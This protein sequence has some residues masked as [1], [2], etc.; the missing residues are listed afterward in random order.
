MRIKKSRQAIAGL[1]AA[2]TLIL[3]GLFVLTPVHAA[4]RLPPLT[5][6]PTGEWTPGKFVWFEL[7]TRALEPQQQFYASVFGWRFTTIDEG[8]NH[9]SLIRND[10]QPVA[11]MFE[12]KQQEGKLGAL[13]IAFMSSKD[14]ELVMAAV[15]RSGGSVHTAPVNL[16]DRGVHALFRDPQ[17]ALFGVL[18][19]TRGDPLD[20]QAAIGSIIWLDLFAR[21]V[22]AAADFYQKV[23]PYQ[24]ETSPTESGEPENNGDKQIP[25]TFLMSANKHRAGIVSLPEEANRA[26]WLPYVRVSDV[27]TTLEKVV[28]SGGHVMV[29]PDTEL[30]NGN[31]AIFADPQG[32]I[33]GI[34][35]WDETETET[36]TDAD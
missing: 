30:F 26:G 19:S 20:V 5:S 28:Q 13:W 22:N 12:P 17:G 1:T 36:E 15:K 21:D 2:F 8:E 11:G 4:P 25:R 10:Q 31:L 6:E 27:E 3:Q 34:V 23:A 24:I 9:Y 14:P 7:A 35:K 16:P 29:A 18:N 32:G 33:I